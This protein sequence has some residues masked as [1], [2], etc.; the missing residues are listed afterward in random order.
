LIRDKF[1]RQAVAAVA[2]VAAV[3]PVHRPVDVPPPVTYAV[4]NETTSPK[5][6]K[7][8]AQGCGGIISG[9]TAHSH[10]LPGGVATFATPATWPLLD[11]AIAA[12]RPYYYGD[13]AYWRRGKYYRIARNAVQYQP[14]ASALARATP[15]RLQALDVTPSADWNRLGTSIVVCPNS[16]IYMARFGVD[17]HEWVLD[18][19]RQVARVSD[20]PIVVRHKATA[21]RRPLYLDLHDAWAVVVFSSNA[22]VEAL[23]AGV[24]VFVTAPWASTAAMGKSSLAEIETPY[25]P[26]LQARD[27]F[28]WC[29]A[30]HQWTLQE[31][32]TGLA[33]KA[34]HVN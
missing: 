27:R 18:V 1:P 25:Y 12:E 14:T 30:E 7:A 4:A 2:A 33:W 34:L 9:V 31:I 8:F 24:P 29:L 13:H 5:F 32:A 3:R 15:D 23:V 10:L 6:A 19:V 17:A 16:T 22:A 28:V 26:D 11:K 20:R 21:A